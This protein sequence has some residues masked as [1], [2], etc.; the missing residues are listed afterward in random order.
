MVTE[1]ERKKS[2][3]FDKPILSFLLKNSR[4]LLA[5]RVTI[6]AL[7]FYALYFGFTQPEKTNLFTPA[8]FWGLFWALFMVVTLPTFGR[9]FC[10]VCPHGFLGKY[11]TDFGLK[12]KMPKFMQNRYIGITILLVGWWGIYYTFAGFWKSPFNTAMM[13]STMTLFAFVLYYIYRDMSYC[14]YICPIGTLTRAYDKLSFTKLETYSDHCKNC[15]TFECATACSYNLKPFTF[16]KKNQSDDCTLCM[17]CATSCEAVNFSITEPAQQ[18]NSKLKILSSEVWT[19][20]LILGAIPVSMGFAHGLERSKIA[21][22][23]I[24]NQTA[25]LLN[26]SEYSG[27]FAFLYALIFTSFFAVSGL[28]L[29]SKSLKKDYSTVFTSI[30]VAYI[31]LFIFGSLGHTLETF[32]IK[33][34]KLIV[35]GFAQAFMIDSSVS[36][37]AKRGD[38]WLHIFSILKW[39]GVAWAFL[40]IYKRLKL[41]KATKMRKSLAFI[42]SSTLLFSFI[43]LNFYKGY[44]FKTYGKKERTFYHKNK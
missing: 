14:K 20:I 43:G 13:F 6:T 38:E 44:V 31:P 5:L 36:N 17:D 2:D 42:F 32:F 40:L 25:S 11:I 28:Y 16:E 24:W 15:R 35:D 3:L 1:V 26:L 10:G 37:L 27:G 29:A 34:Y 23:M 33:D 4:F 39:I 41:F 12:K 21:D 18:L 22:D 30:G 7:F 9:I 19:Y 8:L